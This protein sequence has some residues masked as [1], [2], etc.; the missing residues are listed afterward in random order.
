MQSSSATVSDQ[1]HQLLNGH[2]RSDAPLWTLMRLYRHDWPKLALS[3]G[4]YVIK[5]SPE[6]IRPLVIANVIDIVSRPSQ[7][8]VR[9]LWLNGLVLAVMILQNLPTHYLHIRTMSAAT[10]Q[11]E[12][13][14]APP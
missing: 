12:S 9:E 1:S 13:T 14:G 8:D 7:H 5:H 6:W 11:M 3:F 4:F 2:Y 10:R